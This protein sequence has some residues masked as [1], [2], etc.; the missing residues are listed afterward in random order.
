MNKRLRYVVLISILIIYF[1]VLF[2]LYGKDYFKKEK[3]NTKLIIGN[4]TVW[5]LNKKR[6]YFLNKNSDIKKLYW[7]KFNVYI[8]NKSMGKYFLWKDD[9]IWYLF[10]KDKNSYSYQGNLLAYQSSHKIDIKNLKTET[11]TDYTYVKQVLTN[12][13]IQTDQVL[14][15]KNL[16]KTDIDNDQQEEEFYLISNAFIDEDEQPDKIFSF[17]FMVK[18][19]KIYMLYN[20]IEENKGLNGCQPFINYILDVDEDKEYEVILTCLQYDL[21]PSIDMLYRFENDAF[22]ILISNQ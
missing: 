12:N 19:K 16:I 14:T 18:N 3:I 17:V 6:W 20:S 11:I 21:L 2:F 8:N 1:I 15:I 13:N 9:D 4:N 10:D 5:E 22:K 7:Q